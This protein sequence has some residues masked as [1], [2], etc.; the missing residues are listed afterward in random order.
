MR[1]MGKGVRILFAGMAAAGC[2][3][4]QASLPGGITKGA[5]VEG[6]TEYDMPNGLR[7]LLFPD[8]TKTTTTVNITYLVGSRNESYGETGMAHLLEHLL[9][10]PSPRH[11][12]IPQEMNAHGAR[13]NGTTFYDRTNYFETFDGTD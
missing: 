7:V 1:S 8:Q 13:F 11:S 10:K 9:F 12:N 6:I 3:A 5:S 2:L 4:A